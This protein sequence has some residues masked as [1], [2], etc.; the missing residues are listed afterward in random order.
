MG[1]ADPRGKIDE[2]YKKRKCAKRSVFYVY[3][4]F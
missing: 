2:K 1:S 4:I 3:V